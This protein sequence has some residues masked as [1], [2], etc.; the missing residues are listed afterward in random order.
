MLH[1]GNLS[2]DCQSDHIRGGIEEL[3]N[4]THLPRSSTARKKSLQDLKG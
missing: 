4:D 2:M 1:S 3:R